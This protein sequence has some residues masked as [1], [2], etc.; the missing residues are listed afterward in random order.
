MIITVNKD[1]AENRFY[2][3]LEVGDI[4]IFKNRSYINMMESIRKYQWQV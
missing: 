3:R 4:V 2:K 1:N